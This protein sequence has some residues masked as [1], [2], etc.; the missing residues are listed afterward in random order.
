MIFSSELVKHGGHRKGRPAAAIRPRENRLAKWVKNNFEL[1][2]YFSKKNRI[3]D[4][5]DQKAALDFLEQAAV[6]DFVR[7]IIFL[8]NYEHFH[9]DGVNFQI[10]LNVLIKTLTISRLK[11]S[12]LAHIRAVSGYHPQHRCVPVVRSPGGRHPAQK[13]PIGQR[14]RDQEYLYSEVG[15]I[16]NSNEIKHF[17]KLFILE[18]RIRKNTNIEKR[19]LEFKDTI[20]KKN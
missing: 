9:F 6:H 3:S 2:F 5:Q 18:D 15:K 14:R 7:F 1:S 4:P 16:Q 10:T 8:G 11:S 13:R 12:V 17:E 19:T 20:K